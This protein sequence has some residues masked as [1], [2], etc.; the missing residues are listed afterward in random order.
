MS[1]GRP[2]GVPASA[3]GADAAS[4]IDEDGAFAD[5]FAAAGCRAFASRLQFWRP[6]RNE[7]GW[8]GCGLETAANA[9]VGTQR[10]SVHRNRLDALRRSLCEGQAMSDT[11][12]F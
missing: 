10:H 2:V 3:N 11:V 9:D 7:R 8:C 5:R 4:A 1:R 6:I 12:K